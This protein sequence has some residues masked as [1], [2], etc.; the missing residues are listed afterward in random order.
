MKGAHGQTPGLILTAGSEDSRLE[1][2][3]GITS[4]CDRAQ[5]AFWV[6]HQKPRGP[7]R[8]NAG[9]AGTWTGQDRAV[10]LCGNCTFLKWVERHLHG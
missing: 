5:A 8:E 2:V 7:L 10:A 3:S 4:E 1:F 6:I 9:F